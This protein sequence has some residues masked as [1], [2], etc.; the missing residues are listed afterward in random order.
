MT[1][2]P[3]DASVVM[4]FQDDRGFRALSRM[5]GFFDPDI[6]VNGSTLDGNWAQVN[7]VATAVAAMSNAKM[8]GVSWVLRFDIAQ[9]P[10]TETGQY[11]LVTQKAR[12]QGGTGNGHYNSISI[13]APK[14]AVFLTSGQDNLIVV[15]PSL[16]FI[17]NLQSAA[18]GYLTSPD[19]GHPFQLFF[20]GQYEGG[21]P[22]RRRVLQGK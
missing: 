18:A 11:Q 9:E 7:A 8:V 16:S 4:E 21:K 3:T 1:A 2:V 17:T 12:L 6:S 10:T 22:R 5:D 20:G 13:P 14:D 15:D 19:G